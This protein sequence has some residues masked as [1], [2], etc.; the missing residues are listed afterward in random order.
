MDSAHLVGGNY[1]SPMAMPHSARRPLLKE[2]SLITGRGGGLQKRERGGGQ[3]KFY[4]YKNGMGGGSFS[5]AEEG[6]QQ[7]LR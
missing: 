6:A 3:V 5:Y 4:P 1:W 2:W 7:V